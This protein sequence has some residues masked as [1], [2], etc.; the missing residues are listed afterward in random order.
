MDILAQLFFRGIYGIRALIR[1]G[2][3]DYFLIQ[4]T[5]VLYRCA[6][7]T[8]DFLDVVTIVP[9]LGVTS[10][11][12]QQMPGGIPLGRL[13]IYTLLCLNGMLIALAIHIVVAGMA[14]ITQEMENTIWLYRDVMT[15]GRFP[16]DIYNSFLRS[17]LTFV[18]PVAVMISFPA[19]AYLGQLSGFWLAMAFV[20]AGVGLAASLSFWRYATRRYTST[21][22]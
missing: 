9:V 4:P 7:N 15:L 13:L 19:K 16:Y 1:E 20:I 3:F 8:V 6:F 10:Y 14:V 22:S 21:S 2:D 11:V 5:N 17:V 12:L 18:I